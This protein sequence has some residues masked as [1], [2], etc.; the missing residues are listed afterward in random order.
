MALFEGKRFVPEEAEIPTASMADIAFL[1]IIFFIL[2]TTFAREKGIKF[3]LPEQKQQE[4]KLKKDKLI[5]VAIND[6]G[7]VFVNDQPTTFEDLHDQIKKYLEENNKRI[8]YIKT[9]ED[10]AYEKMI[11]AFDVA[12]QVYQEMKLPPKVALGVIKRRAE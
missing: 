2:T 9:H 4:V 10:A 5:V 11:K 1:L 7:K 8:V 3:V 12:K 6:Q